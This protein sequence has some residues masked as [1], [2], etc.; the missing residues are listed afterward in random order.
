LVFGIFAALAEFERDLICE[1]PKPGLHLS[2]RADA[3][4]VRPSIQD[5]GGKSAPRDAFMQRTGSI[6]WND[7]GS[8]PKPG[9]PWQL[10]EVRDWKSEDVRCRIRDLEQRGLV[11]DLGY[12]SEE[13]LKQ[14]YRGRLAS[15][16]LRLHPL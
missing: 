7:I 10:P 1:R 13:R 5:D 11:R 8:D 15:P 16:S 2:V 14:L 12:V 4:A 9:V 3:K 6:R